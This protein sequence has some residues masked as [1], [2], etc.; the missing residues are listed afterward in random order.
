MSKSIKEDKSTIKLCKASVWVP[1]KWEKMPRK[2]QESDR[3]ILKE[4]EDHS[5]N[6]SS[7][8]YKDPKVINNIKYK[9]LM[10]I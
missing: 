2:C 6:V 5:L 7:I 9:P 8:H 4:V 3:K 1:R 10:Q